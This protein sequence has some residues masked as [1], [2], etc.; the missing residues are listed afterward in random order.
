MG[1]SKSN[2]FDRIEV[3]KG[4]FT[5]DF[6][7]NFSYYDFYR[8]SFVKFQS[9]LA[10]VMSLINLLI[11]ICKVVSEFLLN[12]KMNKDI[13]RNIITINDDE[14]HIFSKG[15]KLNKIF[16]I[17]E[18][19]NKEKEEKETKIITKSKIL[20]SQISKTNFKKQNNLTKDEFEIIDEKII[21][22]MKK[23]NLWNII[24]SFFCKKDKKLK[25]IN[26]CDDLVN[27]DLCIEKIFKRLYILENDCNSF[28]ENNKIKSYNSDEIAKIKKIIFKIGKELN[29]KKAKKKK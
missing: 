10:D 4:I 26:L 7:M 2:L 11:S 29:N 25:L 14:K 22:V 20:E 13:I 5:I 3:G 6:R 12:K 27:K 16:G 17:D 1:F 24:R 21:Y 9:F 19:T 28:L 18:K 15:N 23:L 8:R